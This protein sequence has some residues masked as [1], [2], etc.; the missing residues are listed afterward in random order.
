MLVEHLN[1]Q[2][3]REAVPSLN[4]KGKVMQDETADLSSVKELHAPAHRIDASHSDIT[5][6]NL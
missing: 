3:T 6:D 5:I 4:A 1:I 2:V